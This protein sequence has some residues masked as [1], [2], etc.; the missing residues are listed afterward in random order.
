MSNLKTTSRKKIYDPAEK[1]DFAPASIAVLA[2]AAGMSV[3]QFNKKFSSL[4][5]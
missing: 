1:E 2:K 4:V 3:A 5:A